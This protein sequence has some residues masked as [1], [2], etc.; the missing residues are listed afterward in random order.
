MQIRRYAEKCS[1]L[2]A[3]DAC[4]LTK[5]VFL[6]SRMLNKIDFCGTTGYDHGGWQLAAAAETETTLTAA[7]ADFGKLS[8]KDTS[9]KYCLLNYN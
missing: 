5:I 1:R 9:K 3:I 2:L 7:A 8:G 4:L 6:L